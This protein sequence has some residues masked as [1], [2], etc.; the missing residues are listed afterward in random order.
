MPL[1]SPGLSLGKREDKLGIRA[2]PTCNFILENVSI[3]RE[4]VL[5]G[6]GEG[7]KIAMVQL[8]K[9]RIGIAAQALGIGQAA[10]DI[11]VQYAANR[12]TFGKP[13]NQQQAVKVF[14]LLLFN[15]ELILIL[16]IILA[17]ICRYGFKIR[18]S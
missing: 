6:I 2:S 17:K 4:N 13:I 8:D 12:K 15:F 14:I 5:G 3:P 9:A 10:L 1:P 16:L 11:A 7:F 18:S